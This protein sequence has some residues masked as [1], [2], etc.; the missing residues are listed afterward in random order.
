MQTDSTTATALP[1]PWHAHD[2]TRHGPWWATPRPSWAYDV[3]IK[4]SVPGRCL[5]VPGRLVVTR[6]NDAS[7]T[8]ANVYRAVMM[9][10]TAGQRLRFMRSQ[11]GGVA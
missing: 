9:T 1:P 3:V 11:T 5:A 7:E 4:D 10:M 6:G 2:E 8:L